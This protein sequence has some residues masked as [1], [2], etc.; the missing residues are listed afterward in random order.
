MSSSKPSE[1]PALEILKGRWLFPFIAPPN[2]GKGTQTVRLSALFNIPKLDMGASL[3]E[4]GRQETDLGRE[5]RAR[6]NNGLLVDTKVVL[7]VLKKSLI[8]MALDAPDCHAFILDG[9][10]RNKS[11]VDGL[12]DLCSHGEVSIAKAFYLKL[13]HHVIQ[14]RAINRRICPQCGKIYNLLSKPSKDKLHCD[15][16]GSLLFHREDDQLAKVKVRL[17]LFEEET[18]PMIARFRENGTLVKIDGNQPVPAVTTEL[19]Q[20][21]LPFFPTLDPQAVLAKSAQI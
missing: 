1:T 11:Q 8:Q 16:D 14:E 21:M 17:N 12:I 18:R 6:L 2:G 3:R 13:P 10:P 20:A 4:M 15:D 9:F 5:I 19:A 7:E